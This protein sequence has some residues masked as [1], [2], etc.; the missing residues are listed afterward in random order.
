MPPQGVGL[1]EFRDLVIGQVNRASQPHQHFLASGR[2]LNL[3][4]CVDRHGGQDHQ[5]L[6]LHHAVSHL[7]DA[8]L[9]NPESWLFLRISPI[10]EWVTY[11]KL[12]RHLIG[13]SLGMVLP[14]VPCRQ[15]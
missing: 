12:K 4:Y 11:L 13:S 2:C 10:S 15:A 8:G 3:P 9:R 5:Q 6:R 7:V 14:C 1:N